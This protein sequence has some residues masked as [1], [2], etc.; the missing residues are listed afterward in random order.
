MIP[1]VPVVTTSVPVVCVLGYMVV[2]SASV[3]TDVLFEKGPVPSL[4]SAAIA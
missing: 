3:R 1:V 4:V 2:S